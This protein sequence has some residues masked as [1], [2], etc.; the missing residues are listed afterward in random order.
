MRHRLGV[1]G[2]ADIHAASKTGSR[3]LERETLHHDLPVRRHVLKLGLLALLVLAAC[4]GQIEMQAAAVSDSYTRDYCGNIDVSPPGTTE[5]LAL[6][7][8]LGETL[9]AGSCV[10]T[11]AAV[12]IEDQ[13]TGLGWSCAAK[14]MAPATFCVHITCH[15]PPGK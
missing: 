7:C 12:L 9:V 1:S 14:A 15:K 4:G 2:R 10:V 3:A 13:Q 11:D 8:E 6:S 5:D